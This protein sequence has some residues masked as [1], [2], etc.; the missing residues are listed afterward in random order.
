MSEDEHP[1]A[2][3]QEDGNNDDCDG[4]DN[5]DDDDDPWPK[6]A[7]RMTNLVVIALN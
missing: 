5:D 6:S 4:D 2:R 1:G 7:D 3:N